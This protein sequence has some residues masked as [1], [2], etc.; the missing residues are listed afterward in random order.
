MRLVQWRSYSSAKAFFDALEKLMLCDDALE[1]L[2]LFAHIWICAHIYNIDPFSGIWKKKYTPFLR[3]FSFDALDLWASY[4]TGLVKI[5]LLWAIEINECFVFVCITKKFDP[6]Y[7]ILLVF[8]IIWF[9]SF[10]FTFFY[11]H[12][13]IYIYA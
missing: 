3:I 1:F 13:I 12:F 2:K 6:N 8:I 9:F 4:A 5:L 7:V 11:S 10:C